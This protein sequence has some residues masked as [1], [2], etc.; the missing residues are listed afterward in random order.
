MA[1]ASH[2]II[3]VHGVSV[4]MHQAS[5]AIVD[6]DGAFFNFKNNMPKTPFQ[7]FAISRPDMIMA[8]F[9]WHGAAEMGAEDLSR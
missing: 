7:S 4:E 9:A 6:H 3:E 1:A 5:H 2:D 8:C